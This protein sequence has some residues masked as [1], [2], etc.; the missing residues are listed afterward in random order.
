VVGSLF[1]GSVTAG[2]GE[3]DYSSTVM[4]AM[5]E[6]QD[7]PSWVENIALSVT[8]HT[9][10]S[11]ATCDPNGDPLN[12][13][14]GGMYNGM[15]HEAMAFLHIR[16]LWLIYPITILILGLGFLIAT[17]VVTRRSRVGAWKSSPL[18]L[19]FCP[20]E[21]SLHGRFEDAAAGRGVKV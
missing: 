3:A 12:Y 2:D 7:I 19:L 16:W 5:W 11:P 15:V 17:M 14:H 21:G 20:L 10:S 8:N 4:Q 1:T 9:R 13:T 18:A 6:A